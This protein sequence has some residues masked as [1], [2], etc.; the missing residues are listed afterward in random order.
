MFNSENASLIED[1]ILIEEPVKKKNRF[2]D[3]FNKKDKPVKGKTESFFSKKKT[4]N[5]IDR[6]LF[7]TDIDS[8]L[9]SFFYVT[10]DRF[11]DARDEEFYDKR[12]SFCTQDK[13]LLT[14]SRVSNKKATKL[15]RQEYDLFCRVI[16]HSSKNIIYGVEIDRVKEDPKKY[17]APGQMCIDLLLKRKDII[18][19]SCVAG[20]K[21]VDNNNGDVTTELIFYIINA[22]GTFSQPYSYFNPSESYIN[23]F[24][25][26]KVKEA[27]FIIDIQN[28]HLFNNQDFIDIFGKL[29]FFDSEDK[30]VGLSVDAIS[31]G[32]AVGFGSLLLS[33][34]AFSV[35]NYINIQKIKNDKQIVDASLNDFNLK[36]DQ[37]IV[38]RLPE[39]A[40]KIS[41]PVEKDFFIANSLYKPDTK[42]TMKA[43]RT[44][45]SYN[46]G[47]TIQRLNRITIENPNIVPLDALKYVIIP[48]DKLLTGVTFDGLNS[49]GE[50]S[51]F[52]VRYSYQNTV[53][54]LL[55]FI[56]G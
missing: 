55:P 32:V 31:K 47:M 18:P 28:I 14:Q 20:F 48:K 2:S 56:S 24:I 6:V 42:I 52:Y 37:T 25:I 10:H 17:F 7:E 41:L 49:T 30:I 3:I 44:L 40:L 51:K 21:F 38:D 1:A 16:N 34:V 43:T 8:D 39:I 53:S 45:V 46:V 33:S 35:W 12:V 15:F 19:S 50:I 26:E 9:K 27:G 36:L 11:Y 23:T 4:N 29:D 13:R 54:N 22:D 5:S